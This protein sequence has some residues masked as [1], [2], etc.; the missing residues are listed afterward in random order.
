MSLSPA[1]FFS[2]IA[3]GPAGG[4]AHWTQTSDGMRVRVGHWNKAAA[5]GTVLIFPGRTEF[6]EKYG[7]VAQ[8][9]TAQSSVIGKIAID[10]QSGA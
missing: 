2:D 6:I 1:P 3:H 8:A 10:C 7:Q 4:A 9:F 5:K